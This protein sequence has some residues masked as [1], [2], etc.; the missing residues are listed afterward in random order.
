VDN[1]CITGEVTCVQQT[2]KQAACLGRITSLTSTPTVSVITISLHDLE[3]LKR[4]VASVRAQRYGGR[5][6]HI[7]IDGGSGDDVVQYLS[8][9]DP[10]FAHWQS[11]PDGGRYDAMNQGIAHASGDL[12]WFMHSGDCFSDP[13]A[14][15]HVANAI[16]CRG[17]ARDVWGYGMQNLIT[18]NGRRHGRPWGPMPFNMRKFLAGRA[19]VPHQA[20]FFGSSLVSRLGSYDLDFGVAADQ[21]FI[22]RA[23]L[24]Q[25]PITIERVVCDFDLTGAGSVR[26]IREHFRDFRRLW[27]ACGCYPVRGRWASLV[28]ARFWEYAIRAHTAAV[29]RVTSLR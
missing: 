11:E 3:G 7:V 12:L 16:S 18:P 10:G 29:G 5:I 21:Q 19:T 28:Y 6:E 20:A 26:H 1:F 24:L 4:T 17:S 14:V 27:D 8:G 15:A 13:D 22:L 23:A 25:R 9:C 2:S